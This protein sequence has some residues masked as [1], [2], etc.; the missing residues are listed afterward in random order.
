M[1]QTER[2][3]TINTIEG[4]F[5]KYED[6]RSAAMDRWLERAEFSKATVMRAVD[7]MIEAGAKHPPNPGE[8]LEKMRELDLLP[9]AAPGYGDPRLLAEH[10]KSVK[11]QATTIARLRACTFRQA[12]EAIR[13][14]QQEWLADGIRMDYLDTHDLGWHRDR[15]AACTQIL[16]GE[17]GEAA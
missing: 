8:L 6:R 3:E 13:D 17:A 1:N 7:A 5:H 14:E 16:A 9:H 11:E 10:S 12:V 15:I 2:T 4:T